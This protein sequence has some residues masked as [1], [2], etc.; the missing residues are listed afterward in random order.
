MRLEHKSSNGGASF[1]FRPNLAQSHKASHVSGQPFKLAFSSFHWQ[2]SALPS[3]VLHLHCSLPEKL[4]YPGPCRPSETRRTLGAKE[5]K[6]L[7]II[8]TK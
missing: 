5:T 7:N 3:A 1:D 8:S 6:A 2:R 4:Q